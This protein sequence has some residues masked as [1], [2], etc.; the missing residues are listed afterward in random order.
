MAWKGVCPDCA[1]RPPSRGWSRRRCL[2][3]YDDTMASLV[4]RMKYGGDLSLL[5][6][7]S[8]ELRD[9]Y[10]ESF[11]DRVHHAVVPVPLAYS[12]QKERG[13]NQ[14]EEL[15]S[16]LPGENGAGF[17]KRGRKTR[18]QSSLESI[19]ERRENVKGAFCVTKEIRGLSLLLVDDVVTSGATTEEA[20]RALKRGGARRV[21]ILALCLARS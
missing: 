12:R 3:H 10:C 14:A 15:A 7:F 18:P 20:A 17:L 2:Y 8:R 21:D 1:P 11:P 6:T 4:H 19:R 5:R 9:F 13:F 16:L